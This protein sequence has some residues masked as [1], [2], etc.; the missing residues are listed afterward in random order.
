MPLKGKALSE[1]EAGIS[2]HG[3]FGLPSHSKL[4]ALGDG[5]KRFVAA[6]M[7][8]VLVKQMEGRMLNVEATR[9]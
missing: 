3:W 7:Q 1:R 8:I 6:G 5:K 9:L 2:F 4:C